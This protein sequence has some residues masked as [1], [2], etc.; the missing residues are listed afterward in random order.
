M[1][2]F[3]DRVAVSYPPSCPFCDRPCDEAAPLPR[4]LISLAGDSLVAAAKRQGL[5]P[6]GLKV[7]TE[8]LVSPLLVRFTHDSIKN[9][10][11]DFTDKSSGMPVEKRNLTILESLEEQLKNVGKDDNKH[12]HTLEV[13]WAKP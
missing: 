6:R 4:E 9:W 11:N 2:C 12:L 5:P 13:C 10:F 1:L 7:G 8:W 3:E